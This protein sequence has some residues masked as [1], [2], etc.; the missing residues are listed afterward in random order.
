MWL[1]PLDRECGTDVLDAGC[2][3]GVT[4]V[5]LAKSGYRV[6]AIDHV[7]SMLD[8]TRQSAE[9][10]GVQ[11]LIKVDMADICCLNQVSDN[12]FGVVLCLGVIGWLQSP[13]QAI[14]E[15]HRVLNRAAV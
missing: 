13:E 8:L 1:L 12:F 14:R 3:A 5:A 4:S 11:S 10:A 15:M 7:P 2:G 9:Q 6:R